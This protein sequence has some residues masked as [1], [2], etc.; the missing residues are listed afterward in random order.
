MQPESAEKYQSLSLAKKNNNNE[1]KQ[2][3]W[4]TL[5]TSHRYKALSEKN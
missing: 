4:E 2:M 5:V 1:T 3:F